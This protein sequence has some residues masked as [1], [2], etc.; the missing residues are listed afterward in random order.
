MERSVRPDYLVSLG[1]SMYIQTL[2]IKNFRRLADVRIDLSDQTTLLVGANNSGKTSAIELLCAFLDR[3]PGCGRLSVFD[4]NV[5]SLTSLESTDDQDANVLSV[6]PRITLDLWFKVVESDLHRVIKLLPSLD[7]NDTPLG[8]RLEFSPKDANQLLV[9]YREAKAEAAKYQPSSNEDKTYHPWPTSLLD[10]LK[11]RLSQEYAVHYYVLDYQYFDEDFKQNDGYEPRDLRDGDSTGAAILGTLI[12]VDCMSA[13]RHLSDDLSGQAENLSKRLNGY[14]KKNLDPFEGDFQAVAALAKSENSLN[15][16]FDTVFGPVLQRL[17][18]LGYPGFAD[19]H[20][21][22][23][24]AFDPETV[25]TTNAQVHYSLCDPGAPRTDRAPDLPEKY[26]GLGFKNLIYMVVELLDF[27]EHWSKTTNE[28]PPLHLVLIEEPEAHLHAQL[29]QVFIRKVRDILPQEEGGFSTQMVISTHSPHIIYEQ[30]FEPIRYFQRIAHRH[31]SKV[32]NLSNFH[33]CEV[34][35]RRFLLQYMKLTHCDL[36]FADA[37]I[38][39][40]GNVERLLL[41]FMIERVGEK[42]KSSYL[43]ILE[44]GGAF[45]HVFKELLHFLNLT[46]L[47]ITDLDSVAVQG[48][49]PTDDEDEDDCEDIEFDEPEELDTPP[50][51]RTGRAKSCQCDEPNAVTANQSLRKWLPKLSK[52]SDLLAAGEAMKCSAITADEPAKIRVAYQ[53]SQEV[54]WKGRAAKLAGRTLEEA[55]AFENLEWCQDVNQ[56]ALGL[57]VKKCQELSLEDITKK[58]HKRVRSR[59]FKKT[60]FALAL[61]MADSNWKV[62]SYIEEGLCWLLGEVS[63]RSV[64][65][66]ELEVAP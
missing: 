66:T 3:R 2:R 37:A 65:K 38:L 16:Y 55:F 15:A 62:P 33:P 11:K 6:L 7:W 31:C 63:V 32:L 4:F 48:L 61:M 53:T 41:P 49:S 44:V 17:N 14:Y 36:F 60:E 28:R 47:V 5:T 58:I 23:K 52:I 42:L 9:N 51:T 45:A 50:A 22:I 29:Q 20:L 13:Q 8:V 43:T 30:D 57:S 24:S 40:E 10:F 46:T 26:N 59:A 56:K 1:H 12:R 18:G 35:T 54:R 25:L 39:V 27:H 34:G 19:P 21:V 64:D